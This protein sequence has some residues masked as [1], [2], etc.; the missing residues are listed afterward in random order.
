MRYSILDVRSSSDRRHAF[1]GSP[2]S[3]RCGV[4]RTF[5]PAVQ[6]PANVDAAV[7]TY[8]GPT[9]AYFSMFHAPIS[10]DNRAVRLGGSLTS[11]FAAAC[12]VFAERYVTAWVVS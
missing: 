12:V 9:A 8:P 2:P 1:P 5:P 6:S 4:P 7:S 11:I 10:V 3:L